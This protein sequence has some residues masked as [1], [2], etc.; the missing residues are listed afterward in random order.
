MYNCYSNHAYI[1]MVTVAYAFNILIIS[2]SLLFFS[3]FSIYKTNAPSHVLSSSDT[4]SHRHKIKNQPQNQQKKKNQPLE[5]NCWIG[6]RWSWIGEVIWISVDG[7]RWWVD[8]DRCWWWSVL[9]EIGDGLTEIS[10]DGDQFWW[11]SVLME[12]L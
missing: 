7:D 3:L 6:D 12:C 4:H 11:R 2:N 5:Q 1:R 8:V 9:M 10:V